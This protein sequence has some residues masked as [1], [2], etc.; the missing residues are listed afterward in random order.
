M[1]CSGPRLFCVQ[2]SKLSFSAAIWS[3]ATDRCIFHRKIM[4]PVDSEQEIERSG[5]RNIKKSGVL[6]KKTK[7][8]CVV[9]V[10]PASYTESYAA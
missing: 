4:F 2:I 7:N 3:C 8:P 5:L 6:Q 1:P 10:Y 9:A